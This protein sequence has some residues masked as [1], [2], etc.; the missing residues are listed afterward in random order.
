MASP[1]D[2]LFRRFRATADPTALAE[3][4]DR[5]APEILRVALHMT[6]NLAD[7][8]DLVQVTFLEAIENAAT[9]DGARR[10][11]PWLLGILVNQARL[12]RRRRQRRPEPELMPERR[13]A[14]PVEH[15]KSSELRA[16]LDT[17]IRALPSSYQDVFALALQQGLSA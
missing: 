1:E 10:V 5:T 7:A 3:L 9:H 15:A 2:L 6:G 12:L 14:D 16:A 11:L 4:F 13:P 17:A 8:E